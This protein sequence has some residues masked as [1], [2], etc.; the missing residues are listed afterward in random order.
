M[1]KRITAALV[2]LAA[3]VTLTSCTSTDSDVVNRNISQDADNVTWTVEQLDPAKVSPN[4]YKITFK[5]ETIIPD[6]ELR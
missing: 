5:P 1:D 3:T 4:F 6:V 2:A